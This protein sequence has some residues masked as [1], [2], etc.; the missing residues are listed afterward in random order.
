VIVTGKLEDAGRK[1]DQITLPLEDHAFQIVVESLPG[2]PPNVSTRTL[3]A[4]AAF[5]S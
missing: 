1:A 4:N 3:A 5:P 2:T